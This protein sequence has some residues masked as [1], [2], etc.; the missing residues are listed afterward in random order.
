MRFNNGILPI[1]AQA[2]TEKHTVMTGDEWRARGIELA[3][4]AHEEDE[5]GLLCNALACF[6]RAGDDV[7]SRKARTQMEARALCR[8][9]EDGG[10]GCEGCESVDDGSLAS[11]VGVFIAEGLVREPTD[12]C[13]A[14]LLRTSS[15]SRMQNI[16]ET[17]IVDKLVCMVRA[18]NDATITRL[19]CDIACFHSKCLLEGPKFN[20]EWRNQ[21]GNT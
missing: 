15:S 21:T 6:T 2:V 8:Q 9:L 17:E 16:M 10:E 20:E 12:L 7:L 19:E 1:G 13:R 11:S 18:H 3:I 5:D 4:S 14:W